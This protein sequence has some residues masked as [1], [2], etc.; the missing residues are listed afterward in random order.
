[1][2]IPRN[3]PMPGTMLVL[4]SAAKATFVQN[5][6]IKVQAN[7]ILVQAQRICRMF[8]MTITLSSL[9]GFLANGDC[10][11]FEGWFF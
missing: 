9:H 11:A 7:P 6:L 4:P 10:T 3:N 8:I 5:M 1:M 2:P